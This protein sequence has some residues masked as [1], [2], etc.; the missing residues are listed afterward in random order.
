MTDWDEFE[1]EAEVRVP[2]PQQIACRKRLREFFER[3]REEVFFSNQLAVQNEAE[4]FHWITHRAVADLIGTGQIR[5]E[6]RQMKSG[7]AIRLLW[8]RGH[9]YYKRDASRVLSL[10]EEYSDPNICASLGLH[11]ETMILGGFARKQFV[12][13]GQHTREFGE[14]RWER[15]DH[16]IDFIFE[17]DGISYGI[18]VKNALSYMDQ[19][20]FQIKMALCQYLGLRPVFAVRMLPKSW[21]K[22]L[23][24]AGGYAMI[25]KY[26][27]YPWTHV[28]LA[29]RVAKELALPVDAPKA[30]ADGTMDRFVRWHGKKV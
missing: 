1:Y 19:K 27:L 12:M 10:V 29:K 5:T 11:G 18:E 4:F 6:L 9:R 8:H 22:E 28:Q 23:V 16:N 26:Q 15:T 25:L 30:L 20:E 7:A 21:I 24:D 3:N 13:L 2:D 17:R 14:R